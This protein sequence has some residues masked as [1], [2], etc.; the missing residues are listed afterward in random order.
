MNFRKIDLIKHSCLSKKFQ[1]FFLVLRNDSTRDSKMERQHLAGIRLSGRKRLFVYKSFELSKT[2]SR[3][4]VNC[5]MEAR[6][7][8]A[9]KLLVEPLGSCIVFNSDNFGGD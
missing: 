8:F 5:W 9:A 6:R 2:G 4:C 1:D 3:S 7:S